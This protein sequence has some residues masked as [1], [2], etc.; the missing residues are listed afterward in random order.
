[1]AEDNSNNNNNSGDAGKPGSGPL[2]SGVSA[3]TGATLGA[4]MPSSNSPTIAG[5][6][7][8]TA[9]SAAKTS[10]TIGASPS[11]GTT[12]A[13]AP[14]GS[15]GGSLAGASKNLG[16]GS[17][18]NASSSAG[19][20][21]SSSPLGG[22]PSP[23]SSGSGGG[24]GFSGSGGG[25]AGS[26]DSSVAD[27]SKTAPIVGT[28]PTKTIAVV[29]GFFLLLVI[30]VLN[31][32]SGGDEEQASGSNQG[33]SVEVVTEPPKLP[34]PPIAARTPPPQ[35]APPAYRAGANNAAGQNNAGANDGAIR[36]VVNK[37]PDDELQRARLRSDI[38]LVNRSGFLGGNAANRNTGVG[39]T[40][41]GLAYAQDPNYQ[42]AKNVLSTSSAPKAEAELLSASA[43]SINQGK[44]INAVLETALNTA[45]P[46]TL[47][48]IVSRDVYAEAGRKVLI[49]KGSRIIG[50]YN[51]SIRRGQ[52]RVYIIWQR[53]IMPNGTDIM[54][55]SAAVDQLGRS[56][57][58]GEVDGKY[59]E[60]FS[61][62][63]LTTLVTFSIGYAAD[64][65]LD[66][67]TGVTTS[68]SSGLTQTSGESPGKIAAVRAVANVGEVLGAISNDFL[69]LR[70]EITIH[71]GERINIFVNRDLEFPHFKEQ[72]VMFVK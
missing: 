40:A 48:A 66:E 62:A 39:G 4:Q 18:A 43:I 56:G 31:L 44:I 20:A 47:R 26:S 58:E 3:S 24:D 17:G 12:G 51:T 57:V 49:P 54:V 71:Q 45:L 16:S 10:G 5:G 15:I 42:F 53:I 14:L 21:G 55:N 59:W 2:G 61:S 52:N 35:P 11:T 28:Q 60:I 38:M 37:A 70:P 1:M 41:D 67:P 36:T 8:G 29:A 50:T 32:T 6:S 23:L 22:S 46:G 68:F 63:A 64:K 72:G 13:S 65:I 27:L 25:D 7:G 33:K 9:S 34:Q 19:G 30:L 69:D